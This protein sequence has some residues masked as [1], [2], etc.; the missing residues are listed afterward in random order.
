MNRVCFFVVSLHVKNSSKCEIL[1][2][3]FV[4]I[5]GE[6][7]TKLYKNQIPN[8]TLTREVVLR[9]KKLKK[10]S[11]RNFLVLNIKQCD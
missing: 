3:E 7:F 1:N 9:V 6:Q 8:L 4:S 11:H 5:C 2:Y 10:M